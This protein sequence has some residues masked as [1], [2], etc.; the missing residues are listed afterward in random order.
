MKTMNFGITIRNNRTGAYL[1]LPVLPTNGKIT[2]NGG[3]KKAISVDIVNLG[4]VDF[5]QGMDLDKISLSSFFPARYDPGYCQTSSLKKPL[6][7][8][9]IFNSWKKSGDSLQVVCPAAGINTTMHLK[10]FVPDYGRGAEG[11]IYYTADFVELKTIKAV[12]IKTTQTAI[13]KK[14]TAASRPPAPKKP[15]PK[16]YTVKPGDYL[17]KIAKKLGIKNWRTDL[18]EPNKGVIGPNPNL[19]YPGQKLKV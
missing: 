12:K 16:T 15:K 17:I 7:Y 10:S 5:P 19:I 14:K 11:D 13:S 4:T 6:E 18:Y 2:Y 9:D 3:D 8:R 1:T